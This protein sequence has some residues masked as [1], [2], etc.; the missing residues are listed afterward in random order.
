MINLQFLSFYIPGLAA[1][2]IH[3]NEKRR[4]CCNENN[5]DNQTLQNMHKNQWKYNCK[6]CRNWCI[7]ITALVFLE[8]Q[9]LNL[10]FQFVYPF[11]TSGHVWVNCCSLFT[12]AEFQLSTRLLIWLNCKPKRKVN[13]FTSSSSQYSTEHHQEVALDR[14][15]FLQCIVGKSWHALIK[16]CLPVLYL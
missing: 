15:F 16:R 7:W 9:N 1:V 2:L 14:P 5:N 6:L 3:N 10:C 13:C 12:V 8:F 11:L 4:P